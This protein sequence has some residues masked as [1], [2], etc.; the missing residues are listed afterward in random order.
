MRQTREVEIFETSLPG[1]GIRYEFDTE[2]GRRVGV[3]VHRDSQRDVL[4]YREDDLDSCNDS[5]RLTLTES[6]AL[7][8]LLGGTKI[9]E[10]LSDLR[11]EVQGLSIEWVSLESSSP[12]ANKTIGDGKIRTVSGA[13]VVA[14]LRN[15]ESFPGPGPEFSLQRGDMLLVIGSQEGVAKARQIIIG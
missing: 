6:A 12:L 15:G 8:E 10:R 14:V 5:V 11:E 3:M 1:I 4:L 13:S 9:T 7:V 2:N